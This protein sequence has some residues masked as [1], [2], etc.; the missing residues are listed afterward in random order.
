MPESVSPWELADD[1]CDRLLSDLRSAT[2]PVY[3]AAVEASMEVGEAVTLMEC[4][5][6]VERGIQS[7]KDGIGEWLN[8][9][10]SDDEG[11]AGHR[12]EQ[13]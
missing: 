5:A 1:V 2:K 3:E 4:L 11:A 12:E 8:D 9:G 10:N 13:T 6:K 7:A